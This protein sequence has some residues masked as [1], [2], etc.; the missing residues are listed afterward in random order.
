MLNLDDLMKKSAGASNMLIDWADRVGETFKL[1]ID[2]AATAAELAHIIVAGSQVY[3]AIEATEKRLAELK[4]KLKEDL[5]PA[6]FDREKITTFTLA[7]GFRVTTSIA[8]RASIKA[9]ERDNAFEWLRANA[10]GDLI[11]EVVNASTLSATAR[12]MA[13]EGRELPDRHFNSHL[14]NNTSITK[15]KTKAK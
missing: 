3:D 12:T 2:E 15:V 4:K 9:G 1:A 14:Q 13:E 8:L 11:T 10:M 6:A 7:A 5:V